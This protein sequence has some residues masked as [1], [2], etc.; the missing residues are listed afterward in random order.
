MPA[1]SKTLGQLNW[2]NLPKSL[3]LIIP[4]DPTWTF[5]YFRT[6]AYMYRVACDSLSTQLAEDTADIFF[7]APTRYLCFLELDIAG[8]IGS[9][10]IITVRLIRLD[11]LPRN[12]SKSWPFGTEPFVSMCYLSVFFENWPLF[13]AC[14]ML[15]DEHHRWCMRIASRSWMLQRNYWSP[16]GMKWCSRQLI[17]TGSCGE[18]YGNKPLM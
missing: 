2:L 3:Q 15:R 18:W 4:H 11:R 8:C 17:V 6:F 1:L 14:R 9:F 5:V 16:F 10:P 12:T 13:L 7:L